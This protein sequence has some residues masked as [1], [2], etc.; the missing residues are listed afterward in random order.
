MVS[1]D[2]KPIFI[3]VEPYGQLGEQDAWKG[4]QRELAFLKGF[5][6]NKD[7]LKGSV[8]QTAGK[9]Q[10]KAGEMMASK[11]HQREGVQKQ[12][13]GKTQKT[14]GNVKDTFDK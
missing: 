10:E 14:V 9:V 13:E 5:A 2:F 8:K 1:S 12:A 6:M 4:I 11:K 7:Q 3:H